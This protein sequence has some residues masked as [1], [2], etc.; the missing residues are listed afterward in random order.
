MRLGALVGSAM[1]RNRLIME[2]VPESVGVLR[3]QQT[4]IHTTVNH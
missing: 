2:Q 4:L 3:D 1:S